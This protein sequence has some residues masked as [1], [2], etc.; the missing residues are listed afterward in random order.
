MDQIVTI[1]LAN[2]VALLLVLSIIYEFS[3]IVPAK[4]KRLR[5][6]VNGILISFICLI[7]M[8]MPFTLTEGIGF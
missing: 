1:A 3:Y 7:I 2:N 4:Y 5:P 8:S 6:L